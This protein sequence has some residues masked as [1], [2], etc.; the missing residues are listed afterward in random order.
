M[1][2]TIT[3]TSLTGTPRITPTAENE[4]TI[5]EGLGGTDL[6]AQ[7]NLQNAAEGYQDLNNFIACW[8]D[9]Q[10]ITARAA[11]VD[12]KLRLDSMLTQLQSG[13]INHFYEP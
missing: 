12:I 9:A 11:M 7:T 13:D 1:A 8:A 6:D 4:G 10:N 5:H 2:L 3:G